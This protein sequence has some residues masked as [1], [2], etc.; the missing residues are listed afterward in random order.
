MS[1]LTAK[2][3]VVTIKFSIKPERREEFLT[4]VKEKQRKTL[5]EEPAFLQFVVGEHVETKNMFY[6]HQQFIGLEGFDSHRNTPNF[7]DWKVFKQSNPFTEGGEPVMDFYYGNH[8]LEKVAVRSAYCVHAVLC[9]KPELRDEFLDVAR[10]GQK[11]S[12]E[13][14]PLCLQFVYGESTTEANKFILH[15]EYG[16]KE[17]GK[18]GFDAHTKSPPFKKFKEFV[19]KDPFTKQPVMTYY[20]SFCDEH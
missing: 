18:E 11:G 8:N 13:L 2:P 9:V 12:T 7:A 17:G 15:Q 3:Y 5:S 4:L 1:S 14:E 10:N 16:G 19:G 6:I 20:K